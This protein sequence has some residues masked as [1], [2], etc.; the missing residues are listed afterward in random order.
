M[1]II[2]VLALVFISERNPKLGGLLTGLPLGTGIMISFYSYEQGIDFVMKSIPYGISGMVSTIAF[3]IG[4][5]LGGKNKFSKKIFKVLLSLTTGLTFY[6]FTSYILSFLKINLFLS[7]AIFSTGVFCAFTFYRKVSDSSN[8]I[9]KTNNFTNI[10][11][12]I[13][14]TSF[15][16][17]TITGV[18]GIIGTKWAGLIASFPTMLCPLLIILA[19]LYNDRVYPLLLKHL[20]YSVT[21]ILIF[22]LIVYFAFPVTGIIY[23]ITLAYIVCIL[24]ML[25][26]NQFHI[27]KL[28]ASLL[29]KKAVN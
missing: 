1:S 9:I 4:F 11:F 28:V 29:N 17:I 6:L 7:I 5:F 27:H 8:I 3:G 26:L 23:G 25:L 2:I 12:R 13:I 24:Y 20:S 16:V 19:F 21:N 22:Y 10:I 15:I 14:V 18:A